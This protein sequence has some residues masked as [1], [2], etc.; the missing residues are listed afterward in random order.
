MTQYTDLLLRNGG[1]KCIFLLLS[2]DF[3]FPRERFSQLP[4]YPLRGGKENSIVRRTMTLGRYH[5]VENHTGQD[6]HSR[7]GVIGER[8]KLFRMKRWGNVDSYHTTPTDLQF[9]SF[10][11]IIVVDYCC[12]LKPETIKSMTYRVQTGDILAGRHADGDHL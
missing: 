4:D 9:L 2:P 12:G 11:R 10:R 3:A 8:C 6:R 1:D 5:S 7:L